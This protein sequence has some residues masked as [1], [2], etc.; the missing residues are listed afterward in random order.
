MTIGKE[1]NGY[2]NNYTLEAKTCIENSQS[3]SETIP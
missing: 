2:Q 3:E 1:I